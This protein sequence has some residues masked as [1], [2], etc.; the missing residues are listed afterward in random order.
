MERGR[1]LVYNLVV[2]SLAST[3]DLK[4]KLDIL[5]VGEESGLPSVEVH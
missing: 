1:G 5:S 3:E 4:P 2:K